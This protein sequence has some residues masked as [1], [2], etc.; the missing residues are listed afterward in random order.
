M[1]RAGTWAGVAQSVE[2]LICNQQVGGSSPFA[3]SKPQS[4]SPEH[5]GASHP[6]KAGAQEAR[7]E[8]RPLKWA[9]FAGRER[10]RPG[11]TDRAR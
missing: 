6:E 3:S 2:R 10:A 4:A 11:L 9:P 8:N 7:P 5:F 1:Q